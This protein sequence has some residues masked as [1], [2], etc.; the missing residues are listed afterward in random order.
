MNENKIVCQENCEFTKYD[1]N[2]S[3]AQCSCNVKETPDSF[4]DMNI[5]KTKI[6]DNFINIKN[7]VNF[8]FLVCYKKLFC[9]K[10]IVK[11]IGSYIIIAIII[12][13]I[14]TFI[15]FYINRFHSLKE[16]INKIKNIIYGKVNIEEI[17]SESVNKNEMI[18]SNMIFDKRRKKLK[19][20]R[21]SKRILQI[22][23]LKNIMEFKEGEFTLNSCNE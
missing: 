2:I 19:I 15:L 1:F 10:S 3:V 18:T 6:L 11:N 12:F 5:D 20:K 9:I 22:K 23:T 7:F 21:Q 8:N 16:K 14:I 4:V 17:S 13:H